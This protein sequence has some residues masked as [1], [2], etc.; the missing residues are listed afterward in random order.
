MRS[1]LTALLLLLVFAGGTVWLLQ[2]GAAVPAP[3]G[4]FSGRAA[5]GSTG[6]G[7]S[8][9]APGGVPVRPAGAVSTAPPTELRTP[10]DLA[11]RPTAW[12]LVRDAESEA[13]VPAAAVYRFHRPVD[14]APISYTD[15][16]GVCALPLGKPEQLV[17]A[18]AGYLL[19]Q[20]P[21]RPGSSLEQPQQVRLVKDRYCRRCL[22]RFALPDGSAPHEVRVRF[23]PHDDDPA[24]DRALPPGL[25]G[26]PEA[27]QRAWGEHTTIAVLQPLR[28]VH[29]QAGGFGTGFVHLLAAEDEV[30]F[31]R[32]GRF[33]LDAATDAGY[34]ARVDFDVDAVAAQALPVTLRPGGAV[35]GRVRDAVSGAPVAGAVV[36]VR[37]GDPLELRATTGDDGAF[38]IGPLADGA[39]EIEVR[40][41]D[42][43]PARSGPAAA[44]G[45]ALAVDMTPLPRGTLRGR[46]VR[47]PGGG[48]LAGA[49]AT[50]LD[51]LGQ[52]VGT[53]TDAGGFFALPASGVESLRLTVG[54]PGFVSHVELVDP[55]G[56]PLLVALWPMVVEERLAAG[57]TGVVSGSVLDE[58]GQPVAGIALR[59]VPDRPPAA[60]DFA[61]RRIVSGG[62]T[63]VP[64]VVTS[65]PD[66]SFRLE[67]PHAGGA[68]VVVVDGRSAGRGE[69][70]EVALGAET[71]G[72]TLR[73]PVDR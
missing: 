49:R 35:S 13:P 33:R 60:R 44:G 28:D 43:E 14:E 68:T 47:A 12:L 56:E 22:F 11:D 55:G 36:S 20:A 19:R 17:V 29:V 30:R 70:V 54:A 52:P 66:G 59:L 21:T 62:A 2:G 73:I 32:A 53:E 1:P 51:A 48:P 40:H 27:V 3:E 26:Q 58:R 63:A 16:Q 18:R 71:D 25:A 64:A 23:A 46:V 67:T 69:R 10:V 15:E 9:P 57:L 31:L 8:G 5:S 7:D 34:A 72:V 45:A 41:R 50:I 39:L 42:Y 4:P 61:G 24:L 38:E 65:G 6:A 37:E